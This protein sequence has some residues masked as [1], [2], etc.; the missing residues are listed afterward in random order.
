MFGP[1]YWH[2]VV[3]AVLTAGYVVAGVY[4]VGLLRGR[5]DRYHRLGFT[6]PFTVAA[7]LTPVQFVLGTPSPAPSST[8][9][10]KFAATEL[11][12]KTDTHVP[13]YLF[14][15]LLLTGRSPAGSRSPNWT[16]S[17]PDSDRPP[18]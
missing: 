10:V 4:A 16:R 1:E 13:E 8:Q 3:G 18:R 7:I 14:G 11:V 12:W 5:R 2:F 17:S 15:R 9:P 6:L